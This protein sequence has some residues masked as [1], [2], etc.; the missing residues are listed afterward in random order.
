MRADHLEQMVRGWFVGDFEPTSFRTSACEVAVK[1]FA[2]GD[3]EES[4][5]HK[6]ATEITV[7]LNGRVM[8]CGKEWTE[9]DIIIVE[10]NDVTSFEA[11]TDAKLVVVKVPGANDDKFIVNEDE[12]RDV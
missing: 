6:V 5:F 11:K 3:K 2:K 10:P 7:V 8:M 12:D 4:H 9:G 1:Y